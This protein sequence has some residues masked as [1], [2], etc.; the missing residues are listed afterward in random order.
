MYMLSFFYIYS[1]RRRHIALRREHKK[2]G[3]GEKVLWANITANPLAKAS[4]QD[5]GGGDRTF[6]NSRGQE[7]GTR[8]RGG[9]VPGK[10]RRQG[11]ERRERSQN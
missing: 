7:R 6:W 5:K 9:G 8:M 3:D 2:Q 10:G 1:S 11:F 4:L